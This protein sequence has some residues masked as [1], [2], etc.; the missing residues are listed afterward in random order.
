[1]QHH[2]NGYAVIK[3]QPDGL[4]NIQAVCGHTFHRFEVPGLGSEADSEC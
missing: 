1:M 4:V 3:M 2:L